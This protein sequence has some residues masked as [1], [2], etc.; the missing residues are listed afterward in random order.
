M[1][2]IPKYQSEDRNAANFLSLSLRFA[3]EYF[4]K[5]CELRKKYSESEIQL[6]NELT[7]VH[8][9]LWT[10]LIVEVRKLFGK[11][12]KDYENYSLKE[13]SFFQNEPHKTIIDQ[14][15]GNQVVQKILTTS[16]TFTIHLGKKKM[17][18]CPVDEICK[19]DLRN[20]LEK[21]R[22][23]MSKFEEYSRKSDPTAPIQDEET[24]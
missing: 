8:R 17:K 14:V 2:T 3:E 18:I 15:Y 11:S 1:N 24:A 4:D 7:I 5:L 20:Q 19:S 9:A 23:P 21:L 6:S 12:F 22:V 10:S 16:N 13:V